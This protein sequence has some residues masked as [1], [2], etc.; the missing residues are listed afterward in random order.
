MIGC[1]DQCAASAADATRPGDRL[2]RGRCWLASGGA[3]T[4]EQPWRPFR[5]DLRPATCIIRTS[6]AMRA[7][8]GRHQRR[9]CCPRG[10]GPG[11]VWR[12]SVICAYVHPIAP[13]CIL[14]TRSV[15]YDHFHADCRWFRDDP[16]SFKIRPQNAISW[17]SKMQPAYLPSHARQRVANSLYSLPDV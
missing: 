15:F 8:N 1:G 5:S 11:S 4:L 17:H 2:G 10:E 13:C 6:G 12:G 14:T 7:R 16:P 3:A 9:E